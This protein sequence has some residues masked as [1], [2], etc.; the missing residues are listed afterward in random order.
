MKKRLVGLLLVIGM[1]VSV[2]AVIVAEPDD[3]CFPPILDRSVFVIL[4]DPGG[5]D[6][7]PILD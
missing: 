6:P 7:P 2:S 3:D 1:V 4:S 5:C